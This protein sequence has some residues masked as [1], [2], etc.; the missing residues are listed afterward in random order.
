[1]S[2]CLDVV[3]AQ[4]GHERLP[5]AKHW[6]IVVITDTVNLEGVAFEVTG[7]TTTYEVKQPEEVQLLNSQS[8]M[9]RIKVGTVHIDRAFGIE[10]TAAVGTIIQSTPVVRG[11]LNWNCQN[12]VVAALKRLRDAQYDISEQSVE[13]LQTQFSQVQRE[14]ATARTSAVE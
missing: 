12:W 10:D 14:G 8:Y 3:V 2:Q 4:H 13:V 11:S 6:S 7:S 5:G 9:G 1:M